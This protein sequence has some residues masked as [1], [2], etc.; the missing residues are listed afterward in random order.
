NY[1]NGVLGSD[2]Q[3]APPRAMLF[4]DAAVQT[5]SMA[6]GVGVTSGHSYFSTNADVTEHAEHSKLTAQELWT[7]LKS[8]QDISSVMNLSSALQRL[9]EIATDISG[10]QSTCGEF[11]CLIHKYAQVLCFSGDRSG[12]G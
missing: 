12:S 10:S 6:L 3:G 11:L 8:S 1:L 7:I 2:S 4:C 9:T 5:D